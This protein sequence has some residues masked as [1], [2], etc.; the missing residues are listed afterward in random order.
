M[1]NE[2]NIY[3]KHMANLSELDR[4]T[5]KMQNFL[6]TDQFEDDDNNEVVPDTDEKTSKENKSYIN[7][8]SLM[9]THSSLGRDKDNEAI[10]IIQKL[11]VENRSN[12]DIFNQSARLRQELSQAV[13]FADTLKINDL[14]NT[15]QSNPSHLKTPD[16]NELPVQ[17]KDMIQNV[18]FDIDNFINNARIIQDSINEAMTYTEDIDPNIK[19]EMFRADLKLRNQNMD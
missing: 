7:N 5:K 12:Q 19:E 6:L 18:N 2:E 3:K 13:Q 10:N 9:D 16:E 11:E 4:V 8:N 14:E 1:S 15:G 17:T